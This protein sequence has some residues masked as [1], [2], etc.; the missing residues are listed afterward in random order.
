MKKLI[1]ARLYVFISVLF[2]LLVLV[3]VGK[4][5]VVR[6]DTCGDGNVEPSEQCDD[7]GT[8]N[9]DGCSSSCQ[10][11]VTGF[12][13]KHAITIDNAKV[14]ETLSNFPILLKDTNFHSDVYSNTQSAGQDLLFTSDS[15][16]TTHLPFEVVNW[17]TGGSTSEVWVKLTS[18]SSIADTTIYAWYNNASAIAPSATADNGSENVWTEDYAGVWHLNETVTD[19]TT[20]GTHYDSTS[21]G[22]NGSQNYNATSSNGQI[23]N[24]QDFD[25]SGDFIEI[26]D[27][28]TLSN[29][30]TVSFWSKLDTVANDETF[31][32]KGTF[33]NV[34]SGAGGWYIRAK[35]SKYQFLTSNSSTYNHLS[36][37]TDIPTSNWVYVTAT[38]DQAAGYMRLYFNDLENNSKGI[39]SVNLDISDTTTMGVGTP[40]GS[41][42]Y[43]YIDGI[44][45]EVRISSSERS[46]GWISTSYNNQN[47]ST[48]FSAAGTPESVHLDPVL[49]TTTTIGNVSPAIT[50]TP[51][52]GGSDFD[53]PTNV[54]SDVTFTATAKDINTDQYYLAVCTTDAVTAGDNAAPTCD[55]GS[56]AISTATNSDAQASV[57]YTALVGDVESNAWYA[58]V[59]DKVSG[60]GSCYPA[61]AAGDQGLPMGY[62][63][64]SDVP[65]DEAQVTVNSVTY[66][67]DTANNGVTGGTEV[68]TSASE[69]GNDAAVALVAVEAGGGSHMA[70]R[71][72]VVY[73]YADLEGSTGNAIGM[74]ETNDTGNDISFSG[75]FLT[76]GSDTAKSPFG[77]NHAGTFGSVTFTD[78]ASGTI[79]PGDTVR[80]TIPNASLTDA[81]TDGF[82]DTFNFYVCSGESDMGGVT[83]A[84]DY[85]ANTC[86]NGTLLCSHTAVNPTTTDA[87]CDD[88]QSI[89]S[90]PTAHG[91][92]DVVIY[93]EDN[94]SF[95]A[96]GTATQTLTVQDVAPALTSYTAVDTPAPAAGG[97]DTVD[98]SVAFTDDNGD[99]DVTAVEG[100]LFEDTSVGNN[101]TA[102]EN[103]CYIDA[104]CTLTSVSTPGSGKTAT[105][106]DNALG[107]DCQV[108]VWFNAADSSNWEVHAKPTD[109]LGQET[110]FADSN[111][112]L[113][114]PALQGIDIT[115]ASIAYGTVAIGGTSSFAETSMGNVGNQVLDVYIDGDQMCSDFPTCSGDTIA[116]GQQ[117]WH[118]NAST[119]DWDASAGAGP[120]AMVDTASSTGDSTG[121]MN[122]DI[123][124]RNDHT[125]TTTNESIY[126]KLRIPAS[127]G[128][129]SYT[130][131]NTFATTASSTCSTGQSY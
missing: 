80:F 69:D 64:F 83:T 130:G 55:G 129:G 70:V 121:C 4:V 120:Y 115:E 91:A 104:T 2:L 36:T 112:N 106:T 29:S 86:T 126:W 103:D 125:L 47:S 48:T 123:A 74:Y 68:D 76:G 124:I 63:T 9:G 44:M 67:F 8:V 128:V 75:A 127:Q 72:A 102:D 41:S 3:F 26:P 20:S 101:C 31:M 88:T 56:W 18:L 107:V 37:L 5:D 51:S 33:G 13:F 77:V 57:T 16:G 23:G 52:D 92:Y 28:F 111:V 116:V 43:F 17:N 15:A 82:Q 117:K 58:F 40:T 46:S 87:T 7:G 65:D 108:T 59:C 119:F 114:N 60:G 24:A 42:P 11:S 90:V 62:I 34:E 32:L 12:G 27:S 85:S 14:D 39:T 35:S 6:A 89:V 1:G 131:Q 84:F 21:T 118:H 78:D 109:G 105:G 54:G 49:A 81:D 110:G 38:I 50:A 53:T 19:E 100:V 71:G 25:G 30:M 10:V 93:V 98:F 22:A 99:N 113:T 95:P 97:S 45:D 122:R 66:E 61:N 73:V 94:H 96:T 79:E